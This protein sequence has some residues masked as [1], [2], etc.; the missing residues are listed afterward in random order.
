MNRAAIVKDIQRAKKISKKVRVNIIGGAIRII[1]SL[2][3]FAE[4]EGIINIEEAWREYLSE[5]GDES[6]DEAF[7][8]HGILS[9]KQSNYVDDCLDL[10]QAVVETGDTFEDMLAVLEDAEE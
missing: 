8:V 3:A 5:M 7:Y 2:I 10:A 1:K 4:E 9:F 6:L